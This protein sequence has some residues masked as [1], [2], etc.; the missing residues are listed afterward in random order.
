MEK[1]KTYLIVG[2]FA[3]LFII[4]SISS[5]Q[6]KRLEQII[7]DQRNDIV[8]LDSLHV[9]DST[10]VFR[11]GLAVRELQASNA[12]LDGSLI[13]MRG[14]VVQQT[15]LIAQ[16]TATI[17]GLSQPNPIDTTKRDFVF[18]APPFFAQGSFQIYEPYN[19]Y[20]RIQA[21]IRLE[22]NVVET[23]DNKIIATATATQDGVLV[24]ISSVKFTPMLQQVESISD[25]PWNKKIRL[26]GGI[27][28]GPGQIGIN[29]GIM[30]NKWHGYIGMDNIGTTIGLNYF[31]FN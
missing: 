13:D 17:E 26:S 4:M 2:L 25:L 22:L 29:G 21:D 15:N 3:V 5:I 18:R 30:Y 10:T 31:F 16:L 12:K 9:I 14:T 23:E 6:E 1:V 11:Y 27:Q 8:Q 24:D 20:M 7:F 28:A 19:I